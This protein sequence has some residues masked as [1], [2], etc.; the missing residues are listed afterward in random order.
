MQFK[1]SASRLLS[2]ILCLSLLIGI[3]P[4]SA[5][6]T[7]ITDDLNTYVE[8]NPDNILPTDD[9]E[10]SAS[11]N[12]ITAWNWIDTYTVID[13]MTNVFTVIG[14]TAEN[15]ITFNAVAEVLP[16][17]INAVVDGV[18]TVIDLCGWSSNG[19][20]EFGAC[21]G[22]YTFTTYLPEGY[23]L[24][25]DCMPLEVQ[26]CFDES[27]S[28]Y[29]P[30][31][32]SDGAVYNVSK[33]GVGVDY[34]INSTVSTDNFYK[35]ISKKDWNIAPG[36]KESE[37]VL[38][39]ETGSRRQALFIMEADLNNEYV[40]VIN[41]YNGMIPQYGSYK[42]GVMSEQAAYAEAN[43]YGNVVGAM[44]T[45]LSW[46]DNYPADRVGEPLGFIMLDAEILFDPAN[47]G[48][49]YGNVGFP[50]VVV[51]N[52]D[53]DENG[54]PRPAD[55]PK[56]EMP[57]IRSSADLDGWEEQVIPCS[58]GYI[59][60]D[61]VNQH[62][63]DHTSSSAP[64]SVVGIKPDGSVVIML[65][66]GR[67]APYSEG[68]TM[69]ELAEVMLDLGCSYA[70]NCDGGGSST[71]LSQRPG[72]ALTVNNIPSDGSERATTTGILFISTA[73]SEDTFS[74]ADITTDYNYY[75]PGSTVQFDAIA[76]N[77]VGVQ[78]D[79]PE[80]VIWQLSDESF[81][82]ISNDGVFVSN[83]TLGTVSA[84][85]VYEGE[86]KGEKEIQIVWPTDF[87][88][89]SDAMT[90][91][92]GKTVP[93]ELVAT[94]NG[95]ES[96]V[97]LKDG[98]V[99]FTLSD[100]SIGTINGFFFTA[101]SES[102]M[103]AT[104]AALT[105][106]INGLSA[107]VLVNLGKG[108]VVIF[109]FEAPEDINNWNMVDYNVNYASGTNADYSDRLEI[110]TAETG[111]VHSGN[112]ALAV[113][114]EYDDSL[115]NGWRQ[116][117]LKYTGDYIE[118]ANAK[119]LGFWIWMPEEAYANEIDL[120][121]PS[122]DANGAS[123][124][125]SVVL[126][127]IGYCFNNQSEAGWRY[128][129]TDLT[130]YPI[131]YFGL[132]PDGSNTKEFYFQFY[133]Y[134]NQW[135]SNDAVVNTQS[136][137]TYFIDDIIV[138]YSDAADDMNAP[139]FGTLN[140]SDPNGNFSAM[141]GQ[142]VNYNT[143][144][145]EVTVADYA[146]DNAV[147]ID[148]N[149]AKAY[150]DGYE[151]GCVYANGRIAMSNVTVADGLHSVKF[152][153]CDKNGNLNTII[154]K[155]Y[156]AADSDMPTVRLV[157]HDAELTNLPSGSVYYVDLVA[158]NVESAQKITVD[159]D[160]VN[161][162]DWELAYADVAE[163]FELS[164]NVEKYE[165]IAE[166]TIERTGNTS[167]TGEQVVAS[168][169]VRVWVPD[170]ERGTHSG[171]LMKEV[172]LT[173]KSTKGI[174][175]CV[176]GTISTFTCDPMK[177]ASELWMNQWNC[178]SDITGVDLHKHTAAPIDD[179]AAT[180]TANGYIGRTFCE[181]CNSAVEWGTVVS[182][183]GHNWQFNE[184]GK[185]A[186]ANN[187]EELFTG[188]FE[189][190]EYVDGLI[191]ADGWVEVN[192]VKTYYYENGVKLVG[193]YVIDGLMCAFDENGVYMPN[194]DYTGLFTTADGKCMYILSNVPQTGYQKI[195]EVAYYF[196]D[197]GYGYEGT[198]N[199][200]G[201]DCFF[202]AGQY[203]GS[204]SANVV[205]AGWAGANVEFVLDN[206][207]TLTLS[208][209]GDTYSYEYRG[210]MAW[211]NHR[212]MVKKIVIGK[213]IT[214]LGS[215][216]FSHMYNVA[217][218]EF[219]SE[220]VLKSIG[221]STFHYAQ[222][223]R[224]V[225][226]PDRLNSMGYRAFG[227]CKNLTVTLPD[228]ISSINKS[229][230]L[231]STNVTLDVAAGSY[232]EE[233]AI[234]K[235]I[236]YTTRTAKY[237]PADI[238]PGEVPL[239]SGT[240]ENNTSVIWELYSGG[241]LIICGSGAIDNFDSISE[242]PWYTYRN[243]IKTVKIG[244]DITSVG[245]YAFG[246]LYNLAVVVFE[247][248]SQLTTLGH[249]AFHYALK[250]ESIDI[251]DGVTTYGYSALGYCAKLVNVRM[252]EGASTI[253]ANTFWNANS[254]L[255]L[256]VVKDSK[257]EAFAFAMG[258]LYTTRDAQ[259]GL[260][261]VLPGEVPTASGTCGE[262]ATWAF[263]SD[264]RLVVSGSGAIDNYESREETP[265]SAY[266]TKVKL[267]KIGKDITSVGSYA[268]AHMYNLAEVVFEKGSQLT[269]LGHHAFHYALKTE[270]IELPDGITTYGYSALG[271]CAMLVSVRMSE[272][273]STINANTF[274]NHNSALTLN[275]VK[276]SKAEAFAVAQGISYITRAAQY[277]SGDVLPG[278][279]PTASGT[280]G[281]S[282]TWAF[283]ADGR[284]VISGSGAMDNYEKRDE[285]PWNAY[286]SNVKVVKIGKDIT[287]VGSYAFG[288][289]YNLSEV[290]FEEG[291]KLT[292]LGHHAFHYAL[293]VE[294]IEVPD[295]VTTYGYSALGYCAKLTSVRMSANASSINANTFWNHSTKLVVNVVENSKAHAFVVNAG[296]PC[297]LR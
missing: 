44:N 245:S 46:Y 219:E 26:V 156:V 243:D 146:S 217:A 177:V 4:T 81:G 33:S 144:G 13:P 23:V 101:A 140:I 152:A 222:S 49:V 99:A 124:R 192:G 234:A 107:E 18:E 12:V 16:T 114:T 90:V 24:A 290:I 246:H 34:T 103:A 277:G 213:G 265:W 118:L 79:F 135:Q 130:K 133:N 269:T 52:K 86:V 55:I 236:N 96:Y 185:L 30:E 134:P 62:K 98:D 100:D 54:N 82:T 224:N 291:S 122:I 165:N 1:K 176:D 227:Y 228:M 201:Y 183:I 155:V 51:I 14:A 262:S 157:P 211:N 294:S 139:V 8:E 117:R 153:I 6:A 233:Y 88:F 164:Y 271:Y 255:V 197:N 95:V 143:F 273:A 115:G 28:M 296:I 70:V 91:P 208:G 138:E 37:I 230:F 63:A 59:V 198:Y 83:G 225:V 77:L 288:H 47:C 65:N 276:D 239:V 254:K 120:Y 216:L 240:C 226:L 248:G 154:G 241:R 209:F 126:N 242:T 247:E 186:C 193:S 256:N 80:D 41:S 266:R 145:A 72:E 136:D 106:T 295:S 42:T 206:A 210:Q 127:D 272:G 203:V 251:P 110:V 68:M 162:F 297:E 161:T 119:K 244:K 57:Q 21:Y 11:Q 179:L 112:S 147:G 150:I 125:L 113:T 264:G 93:I 105:A 10:P 229:A 275:V 92:F 69:Y 61:G 104:S 75:T 102:D 178:P 237:G 172:Y 284:L 214:S 279:V 258:L 270:V 202:E 252:S 76:T 43:G 2:V 169:P 89:A 39:S 175:E 7:D 85:V 22:S 74:R 293:K 64:R 238:L 278:E 182:A 38:N 190:K 108:S 158:T 32:G 181:V 40:K 205:L 200:G 67:Q 149:S 58:S 123:Q 232:A 263:Y 31:D 207:G 109:D 163:G 53:F 196:D 212:D 45:T 66:D 166:I 168:I 173:I 48:Y 282:A 260:G 221:N 174:L 289:M 131:S 71:Y 25:E 274:W 215:Q 261:D 286:R 78:V 29:V 121:I 5:L 3:L 194:E 128:F 87:S 218:L 94:Y 141:N 20:P 250:L 132:I 151:V 253:N 56:V 287:S 36:I 15:P 17:A 19:Y 249:H 129:T 60:K 137:F 111:K 180:C 116:Y 73:P 171:Q 267:V 188:F 148:A 283:Y 280:C 189:G 50:S 184:E 160:L 257:A 167:A 292:T 191:L 235:S 195:S 159:L 27:V 97:A 223:L 231:N 204:A 35:L 285:A 170:I 199:V 142:T 187:P 281:E 259:Y 220:S 84:Q 268:F 9:V